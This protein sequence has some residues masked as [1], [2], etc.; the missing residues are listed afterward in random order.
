MRS[1]IPVFVA[2]ALAITSVMADDKEKS[3]A[4]EEATFK[5][6]DQD[7]DQRLS[8]A[9]AGGDQMLSDHFAMIDADRDGYLTKRE[10]TAHMKEMKS[11][12]KDH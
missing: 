8:K 11:S 12:R 1:L 10:Y 9:E 4:S 6:L 3:M 5:S 7:N 2:S